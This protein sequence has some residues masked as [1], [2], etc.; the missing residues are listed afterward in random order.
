MKYLL[1]EENGKK[2]WINRDNIQVLSV[3]EKQV[4]TDTKIEL[5]KDQTETVYMANIVMVGNAIGKK[6]N[7]RQEAEKWLQD[8]IINA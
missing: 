2:L 4:K 5:A 8:H 3:S 1:L 6:C 7:S